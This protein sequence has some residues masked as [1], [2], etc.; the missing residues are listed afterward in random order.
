MRLHQKFCALTM[1]KCIALKMIFSVTYY[2]ELQSATSS[3]VDVF[4]AYQV[5][6]FLFYNVQSTNL[7][8][9]LK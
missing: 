4:F 9:V 7:T 1:C 8:F 2:L 5:K 6:L 3:I